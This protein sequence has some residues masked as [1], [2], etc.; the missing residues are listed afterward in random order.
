MRDITI[1]SQ[2][3]GNDPGETKE[4]QQDLRS[5]GA[6]D[7]SSSLVA[8]SLALGNLSFESLWG[9]VDLKILAPLV[10]ISVLEAN[11]L[12]KTVSKLQH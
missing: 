1:L 9:H 4:K 11:D 12:I 2:L 6:Y 8:A 10:N 7:N 3:K 5:I